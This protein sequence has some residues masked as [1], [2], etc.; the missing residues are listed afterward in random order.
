MTHGH[1]DTGKSMV[2]PRRRLSSIDLNRANMSLMEIVS[3]PDMR[4]ASA[5][6]RDRAALLT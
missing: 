4:Y 5:P 1:Q 2:D 6:W 3:R